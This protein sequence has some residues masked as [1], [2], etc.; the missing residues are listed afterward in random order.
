MKNKWK[1]VNLQ[2][3]LKTN[4]VK[5]TTY[6]TSLKTLRKQLTVLLL[7]VLGVFIVLCFFKLLSGNRN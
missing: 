4:A 1:F 7:T 5:T 6:L 2:L 3:K